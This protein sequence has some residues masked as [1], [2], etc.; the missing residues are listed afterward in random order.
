LSDLRVG[1][2]LGVG[3]G[4]LLALLVGCAA[5]GLSGMSTLRSS[6]DELARAQQLTRR[7]M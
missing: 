5:V 2:R 6:S 4:L 1:V 7:V 3:L